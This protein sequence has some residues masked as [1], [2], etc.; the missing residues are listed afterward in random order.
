MKNLKKISREHLKAVQG[1]VLPGMKRCY[2]EITCKA[3]IW[4]IGGSLDSP[5]TSFPICA[6]E[7]YYPPT[8][9]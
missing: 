1:G 2:D 9:E 4:Y 3:R 5:C 6:P 7:G 8:G